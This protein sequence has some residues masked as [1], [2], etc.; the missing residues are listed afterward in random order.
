MLIFGPLP[1]T[2]DLRR[3]FRRALGLLWL[4]V[5]ELGATGGQLGLIAASRIGG[6]LLALILLFEQWG[7][8]PLAAGLAKI[9]H[10]APFAALE[11]L[12]GRLP[13]YGA[14]AVFAVP[15]VLL[16]PL[17][18]F[19]L[20]LIA[21]GHTLSA[22]ALFIGAKVVGTALVARIYNVT[23]AQLMQISWVRYVRDVVA[24]R[25]HA[26]HEEIRR[27]WAWRY[28]R[29][30]KAAVARKLKPSVAL[31]KARLLAVTTGWYGRL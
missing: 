18:L 15:A 7:W 10:L 12:I 4:G 2:I 23:E 1:D 29:V 27:S 25:L 19:A 31:I 9:A 16:L 3:R 20:Y 17:K 28:G 11:R 30:V 8:K 21:Q 5:T 24:P 6:V 13:P 26:L 22:G 14:L